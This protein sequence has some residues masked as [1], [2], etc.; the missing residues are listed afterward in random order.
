MASPQP[1]LRG[2]LHASES[3][4]NLD[5]LLEDDEPARSGGG[6]AKFVLILLALALA[7]GLGYLRW[8]NQKFG[9]LNPSPKPAATQSADDSGSAS[10]SQAPNLQT[11]DSSRPSAGAVTPPA[12]NA[13]IP[14][15]STAPADASTANA[16]AAAPPAN[17]AATSPATN[18]PAVTPTNT[19]AKGS[20][21][22]AN[23]PTLGDQPK[24]AVEHTAADRPVNAQPAPKPQA[25]PKPV[26]P[27]A[28]ADK[29][30]YGRGARQDCDRGLRS[31]KPAAELGN[32]KAAM[33]MG[34]LYSNGT[35]VPR[36]LPTA[37]RWYA[38]TLHK[39]PDNQQAQAELQKLWG[40]MTQPERQL[41]IKLTQ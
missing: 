11:S 38:L 17:P 40:E 19:D 25:P 21:A 23:D 18:V 16:P 39:D 12:D 37:Y 41:A 3:P 34:A 29:Y 35:C 13:T 8:K 22:K 31:L 20:D 10:S 9:W 26:D 30:L 32:A 7:V 1:A 14:P 2:D 15:A 28:E 33:Q 4:R 24:P 6:A 5:Y 27:V 36:D